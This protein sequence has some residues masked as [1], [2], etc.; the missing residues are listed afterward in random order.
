MQPRFGP[1]FR[2]KGSLVFVSLPPRTRTRTR[3]RTCTVQV[4]VIVI[5]TVD[6][7]R[8]NSQN[9]AHFVEKDSRPESGGDPVAYCTGSK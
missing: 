3:T 5:V 7:E 4:V 9:V 8:T 6:P 1:F 2:D